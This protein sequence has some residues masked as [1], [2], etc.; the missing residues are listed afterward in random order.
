MAGNGLRKEVRQRLYG[1]AQRVARWVSD[2]RR[3]RFLKEMIVGL[4]VSGHVHLTKIARS[5]RS[6]ANNVHAEE[7]RLSRHLDSEHWSMR[8]VIDGLLDWSSGMVSEETLI[9]ADLT[10][11]AKY[12]ARHLEGLGRVRD[13]S[14][15]EKRTAPGY[16]LFEA[17]VR[18]RR[19]QLF[20]LV[21]EPLRTYSG[22]PTSE[23]EEILAHFWRIHEAVGK[24]GTWVL[25]R[26][27]D[28]REL[29]VPMLRRGMAWIVRQRGD[30][31]IVT[32][33][34]RQLAVEA[35]AAEIYQ[36]QRPSLW[37][38]AG[39]TYTEAVT[40]PEAPDHELLMVL[41]WR[42]PEAT[43]L[44]LLVSPE[45]RKL[46]RGGTWFVKAYRRRWGVEDATWGIKQRFHLEDFLV[47]S[48][49]S[50]RRLV[51]LVAIAFFWLNLWG[52][53]RYEHLREAFV[54]HPWRIPK[55]VIYLFDWL[56]AQISRF[57]HPRPKISPIDSFDT[58]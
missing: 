14:D 46:G 39:W 37:P 12:Y 27:F 5:L 10:D 44:M 3:Q 35:R 26:G 18:V 2:S 50:I 21:I 43:P 8:P 53:D 55:K 32:A 57:L 20:P 24:K 9:V 52:E 48:W 45:A 40:L 49:R 13:G 16:M 34:G 15:P 47:R 25:D 29:M 17:Y 36:R 1:F 7:K 23:N 54:R 58:G 38:R 33:G 30:R 6:G 22:A 4:V 42:I 31:H 11:V 28:R 19:W 51:S 41:R 56:A